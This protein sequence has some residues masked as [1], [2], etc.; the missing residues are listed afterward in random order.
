M[1]RSLK[2]ETNALLV[3]FDDNLGICSIFQS[4]SAKPLSLMAD[5]SISLDFPPAT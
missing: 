2:L 1:Y 4:I 5:N 3:P